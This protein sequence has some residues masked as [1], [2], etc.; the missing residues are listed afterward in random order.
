MFCVQKKEAERPKVE[1]V[2]E[3]VE[4][5]VHEDNDWGQQKLRLSNTVALLDLS[6]LTVNTPIW[7]VQVLNWCLK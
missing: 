4:E 3:E 7:V 5:I 6:D 1:A 2:Q